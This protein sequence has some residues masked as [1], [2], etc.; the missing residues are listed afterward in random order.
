MFDACQT[1]I[2]GIE[3]FAYNRHSSIRVASENHSKTA[4]PAG[5]GLSF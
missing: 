3:S 2:A 4:H 1:G 5:G